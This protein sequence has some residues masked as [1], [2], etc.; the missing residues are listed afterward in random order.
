MRLAPYCSLNFFESLTICEASLS[1]R[2]ASALI[3]H[4]SLLSTVLGDIGQSDGA[5]EQSKK[6]HSASAEYWAA[7]EHPSQ[8]H[9]QASYAVQPSDR[10]LTTPAN[11]RRHY[12]S[13]VASAMCQ[14]AQGSGAVCRFQISTMQ[15]HTSCTPT[16]Q[17]FLEPQTL[18]GAPAQKPCPRK[19]PGKSG[20]HDKTGLALWLFSKRHVHS[21]PTTAKRV[22]EANAILQVNFWP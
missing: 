6:S 18:S 11:H 3:P 16:P 21:D 9:L 19:D 13:T 15:L 5:D 22:S 8:G 10:R 2:V 12:S 14:R 1:D 7:P 17:S 20:L 4:V